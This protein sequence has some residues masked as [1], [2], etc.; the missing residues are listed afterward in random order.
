MRNKYAE[1]IRGHTTTLDLTEKF[2]CVQAKAVDSAHKWRNLT[3]QPGK[4]G[5]V[6][7]KAV[8]PAHKWRNLYT[9]F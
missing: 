3:G 1:T 2:G 7:A 9:K 5:C 4:F 8:D 6:Q